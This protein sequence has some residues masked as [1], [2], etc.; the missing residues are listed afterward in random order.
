M[1]ESSVYLF[2]GT[3]TYLI[4]QR[5]QKM[6][7]AKIPYEEREMNVIT[8]DL[9]N[10]TLDEVIEEVE[11]LPFL[12]EHK[13]VIAKNAFLFTGQKVNQ[14][15]EHTTATLERL[16]EQPVDFGTIILLVPADKLDERKKIVKL[17]KKHGNIEM[18]NSL[19]GDSLVDWVHTQV[20]FNKAKVKKEAAVL[21]IQT[22]GRDLQ[23]LSKE[24]EKMATYIGENG[25]IDEKVVQ[26]MTVRTTEQN[27]FSLINKVA[28]IEIDS[29]LTML[30]DLLKNKEEPIKII[31][32]FARQFRL[33]LYAKELDR[34]GYST[35]QIASQLSEAPYGIKLALQQSKAFSESQ[36]KSIIK[37][38]AL[39][40][41]EIKTG[42]KDKVL[43]LEMFLFFLQS[44][45][46]KSSRDSVI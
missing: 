18:F 28:N 9:L 1:S 32:L 24:I 11:T 12:S 4:E 43:S 8:Y 14:K 35:Q 19:A 38:L 41:Y 2:Y 5:I 29:A 46:K 17:L 37:Q 10:T 25:L 33:M 36:L 30:Y 27:I 16:L 7:Q 22:V 34:K 45:M 39:M 23:L 6:I 20:A 42:K 13:I 31:V 26:E 21:L 44:L 40:D 15:V 3:E